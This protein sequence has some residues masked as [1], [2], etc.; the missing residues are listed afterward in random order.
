M[1]NV[2]SS[3]LSD[4]LVLFSIPYFIELRFEA[5]TQ[6]RLLPEDPYSGSYAFWS[7]KGDESDMTLTREFDFT[8]VSAPI[9]FSFHTWYDIEKD[10]DYVY[11][12]ISEDG[13][14]WQ[15]VTTPSGTDEDPSGNSYGWGYNN[16][17][18]GWIQEDV[19]LSD[20]VKLT[21]AF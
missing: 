8:Q 6:A 9:T 20:L 2:F 14:H 13:E 15:I 7:N 21:E 18:N 12:E 17:T 3:G 16:V 1:I 10:Y 4:L 5:S 19:D 11:L